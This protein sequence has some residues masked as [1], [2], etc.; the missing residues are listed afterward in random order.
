MTNV[1]ELLQIER[2]MVMKAPRSRVWKALT[3]AKEFARWFEV[4]LDGEFTPGAAL[5][6][7]TTHPDYAGIHFPVYIETVQ[8]ETTFAWRWFPGGENPEREDRDQTTLVTF[9]LEEVA[10]GTRVTVTETGFDRVKLRDRARAYEDNV[11]GWEG[12]FANL[13]KYVEA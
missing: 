13:A 4:E 3:D 7:V 8:P 5:N 6:M 2:T 1:R 9:T 10:G 11:G 12:Q